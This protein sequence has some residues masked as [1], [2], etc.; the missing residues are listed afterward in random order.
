MSIIASDNR[1][2]HTII[3]LIISFDLIFISPAGADPYVQSRKNAEVDSI[4]R[5]EIIVYNQ[6]A[7][8][9]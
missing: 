8:V 7:L 9:N 5:K 2:Q 1:Q 3:Q 4:V 6:L